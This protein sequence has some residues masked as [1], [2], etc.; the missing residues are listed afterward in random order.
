MCVFALNTD[1]LAN[2]VNVPKSYRRLWLAR[3][4]NVAG[5][6]FKRNSGYAQET[7]TLAMRAASGRESHAHNMVV[8]SQARLARPIG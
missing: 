8:Q 1:V 5:C 3:T 4:R 2:Q 7:G 6:Y